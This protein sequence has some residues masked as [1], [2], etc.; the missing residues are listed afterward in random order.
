MKRLILR[1]E[2]PA[3]VEIESGRWS[4]SMDPL[5]RAIQGVRADVRDLTLAHSEVMRVM[6][7]R[8]EYEVRLTADVTNADQTR[9]ALHVYEHIPNCREA[10]DEADKLVGAVY[11]RTQSALERALVGQVNGMSVAAVIMGVAGRDRDEDDTSTRTSNRKSARRELDLSRVTSKV[12]NRILS[13]SRGDASRVWHVT[14]HYTFP[15]FRAITT[16]HADA[17]RMEVS[18]YVDALIDSASIV[19]LVVSSNGQRR[20]TEA[21]VPPDHR[22]A[23][24][25]AQ[26]A[27][28]AVHIKLIP[29][30]A[31][32]G[33]VARRRTT[34]RYSVEEVAGASA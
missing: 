34:T 23:L 25:R 1:G 2:I 10:S 26:M 7:G 19:R 15:A 3:D 20:V 27:K 29:I 8:P 9:L 22:Q 5:W 18:A 13:R 17:P 30:G 33:N 6:V 28:T 21:W 4:C 31:D 24:L 16:E 12:L 32:D 11:S 14:G